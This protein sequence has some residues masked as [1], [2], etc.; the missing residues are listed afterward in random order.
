MTHADI[1]QQLLAIRPGAQWVF[2]D[3]TY[4]GLQWL[5]DPATKP[6]AADLGL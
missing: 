5:D 6:S 2:T 3:T 4:E 1:V